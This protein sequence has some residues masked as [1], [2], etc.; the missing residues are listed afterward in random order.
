MLKV[1]SL[2]G[3]GLWAAIAIEMPHTADAE[4]GTPRK[5]CVSVEF[6]DHLHRLSAPRY[7]RV[8]NECGHDDIAVW[9]G[10]NESGPMLEMGDEGI[11][12][13]EE[14]EA[15][16]LDDL[17]HQVLRMPSRDGSSPYG[18]ERDFLRDDFTLALCVHH[19]P[20]INFELADQWYDEFYREFY[21]L[22]GSQQFE[23]ELRLPAYKHAANVM[24][25]RGAPA[26][27]ITCLEREL[28]LLD[29][30]AHWAT[31]M[32]GAISCLQLG[33]V[34]LGRA[35]LKFYTDNRG[36]CH[37]E[38]LLNVSQEPMIEEPGGAR[39]VQRES[40]TVAV[41]RGNFGPQARDAV[42]TWQAR[43]GIADQGALGDTLA[44]MIQKALIL[45]D[46]DPGPAD[47]VIGPATLRAIKAWQAVF[48]YS[49]GADFVAIVAA[50]L[51]TAILLEGLDPG[52]ASVLLGRPA[53]NTLR[54]WQKKYPRIIGEQA[55][56]GQTSATG[57]RARMTDS[58]NW[59]AAV[60][61]TQ[62]CQVHNESP[63]PGESATWSGQC[64][65]GK[66]AGV[67]RLVWLGSY[68]TH[69]FEGPMRD[70]KRHGPGTYTWAEGDRYEGSFRD[71]KRQGQGTYTWADGSRY[72]GAWRD[73]KPHGWG[74]LFFPN[75]GRLYEGQWVR[76]CF[77]GNDTR[78]WAFTTKKACGFE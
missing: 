71:D 6:K 18:A 22:E 20:G 7:A 60:W 10:A 9:I 4:E 3:V 29:Q 38:N 44:L 54:A 12:V 13:T 64:V 35:L 49:A 30:Y 34:P 63:V 40:S 19:V 15:L 1:A 11:I 65:D 75:T 41:D 17:N 14:Y 58:P 77:R 59:I 8:V 5:G 51:H 78:A 37:P 39:R 27:S 23:L 45:Q 76:G 32:N 53:K 70:G 56:R 31:H 66:A 74:T 2:V 28:A 25:Q 24:L 57:R 50:I 52:P 61:E 16:D 46:F 43:H 72:E 36:V 33:T 69:V 55:I 42:Q 62:V 67:G 48:E 26:E 21:T 68:G 47:G 73:G